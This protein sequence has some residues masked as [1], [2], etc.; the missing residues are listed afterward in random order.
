[1]RRSSR[2]AGSLHPRT[3]AS[4]AGTSQDSTDSTKSI[5]KPLDA[6]PPLVLPLSESLADDENDL[7]VDQLDENVISVAQLT[8]VDMRQDVKLVSRAPVVDA[9]ELKE[10][11]DMQDDGQPGRSLEIGKLTETD[12]I[13]TKRGRYSEERGEVDRRQPG[14]H[15][16]VAKSAS[17]AD[18]CDEDAEM[19]DEKAP[20]AIQSERGAPGDDCTQ[21]Q[22]TA[23]ELPATGDE[24]GFFIHVLTQAGI[25]LNESGSNAGGFTVSSTVAS[26]AR[27]RSSHPFFG[28]RR[29]TSY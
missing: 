25:M 28:F 5:P 20:R 4:N 13:D 21:T 11:A 29:K 27:R 7:N 10:N 12:P 1:M 22:T 8:D 15:E 26:A 6:Q 2:P 3:G 16:T 24:A 23:Q 14:Q 19:F 17:S 18:E 9:I